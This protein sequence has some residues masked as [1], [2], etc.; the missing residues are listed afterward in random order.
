MTTN[1]GYKLAKAF[2][3]FNFGMAAY[4]FTRGLRSNY[5]DRKILISEHIIE[6]F[7]N[8]TMYFAPVWNIYQLYRLFNRVEVKLRGLKQEDYKKAYLEPFSGYC[9]HTL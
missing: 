3:S 8:S 4:G 1:V 2:W 6:S 7:A 9:F 5:D